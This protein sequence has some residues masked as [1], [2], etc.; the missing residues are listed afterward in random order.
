MQ[1]N[2][3]FTWKNFNLHKQRYKFTRKNCKFTWKNYKFTKKNNLVYLNKYVNLSY[4]K[5]ENLHGKF[6]NLHGQRC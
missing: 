1:K 5:M 2:R 4:R 3:K 6:C